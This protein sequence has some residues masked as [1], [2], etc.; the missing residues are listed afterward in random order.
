[1]R[2]AKP[3]ADDASPAVVGQLL[4]DVM[5]MCKVKSHVIGFRL[6]R[7]DRSVMGWFVSWVKQGLGFDEFSMET[8]RL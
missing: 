7:D 5:C 6:D 4:H 2:V 3:D 1:M 8:F